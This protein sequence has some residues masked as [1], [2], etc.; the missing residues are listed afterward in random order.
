MQTE[1]GRLQL[2]AY[3]RGAADGEAGEGREPG[4]DEASRKSRTSRGRCG[5]KAQER[6]R[7]LVGRD[8]GDAA[9]RVP[10]HGGVPGKAA[11]HATGRRVAQG[12]TI[13]TTLSLSLFRG[14]RDNIHLER[15]RPADVML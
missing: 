5:G 12:H 8:G 2:R 14:F 1:R 13:V 7:G 11:Q 6:R 4:L 15:T 3:A 10:V 9:S